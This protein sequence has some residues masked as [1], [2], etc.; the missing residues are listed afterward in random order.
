MRRSTH[1]RRRA[2][3]RLAAAALAV[4]AAALLLAGCTPDTTRERVQHD[5]SA[6]FS[7]QYLQSEQIQ[8]RPKRPVRITANECHSGL[9]KTSDQG[10]GSWHCQLSYTTADGKR[11]SDGFVVL[12]DALGCYQAFSDE[13]R[14]ATVRDRHGATVPDPAVGFDGCYDVYDGR[15]DTSKS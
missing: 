14:D 11:H 3:S 13:H 9:N 1:T 12:I 10:P 7:N 4:P 5:I 6:T 15:T 2:G 8:G